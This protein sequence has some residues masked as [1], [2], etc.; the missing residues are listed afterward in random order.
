MHLRM[1]MPEI[2]V[3]GRRARDRPGDGADRPERERERKSFAGLRGLVRGR[4]ADPAW[5]RPALIGVAGL[6]GV[7][8]VWGLTVSGYANTYYAAAGQAASESW[9]A[10]FF[11][12]TD[13]S[14]YVSLDK[15]PLP[16][17][18]IGISG[19][20]FGFSS[21]SMLLP[22]A[23]C[24]VASV[25]ILHD[26]VRRTVGHR[27]AILAAGM[28]AVTPVTVLVSRYNNP[29]ALLAVLMVGA[30]WAIVRALESG[31]LRHL[32]ISAVLLGLA[33]NTKMLEA[34]L[35]LPALAITFL[36]AGPGG[37]GRRVG[38]TAVAGL[39]LG[40]VSFA[41]YGTMMLI[42]AAD[43]PYVGDST[44]NS[45][46][47]LIFGS[48][49]LSRVAG[50]GAG[51]P[52]FGGGGF[53]GGM[54]GTTGPLRLFDA[55]IGGQIAWLIPLALVGLVHGL[56]VRRA[57]PRTDRGRAAFLLLGLWAVTGWA[58]LSFSKGTFHAYYTSAIGPPVA[59]LAGAG[60]VGL[61]GGARRRLRVA[62]VL[63]ASLALT[64]W[65]AFGLLG[66]APGFAVWLPWAVLGAGGLS[67]VAVLAT[68]IR[69]WPIRRGLGGLALA[70]AGVAV[71]GGP[72]AYAIA[73]VGHGQTGSDPTA[74]PAG[75]G[76]GPG[77]AAGRRFAVA[78]GGGGGGF[79]AVFGRRGPAGGELADRGSA[80][81]LRPAGIGSPGGLRP[82]GGAGSPGGFGFAGGFAG[83][84]ADPQLVAYL[85]AHRDGAEYLVAAT[86]SQVAGLIQLA[87]GDPVVSM[88]GFMGADPAPTAAELAGLVRA[89]RV[90]YVLLG[91]GGFGGAAGPR[92]GAA[93]GRGDGG[94][95]ASV[96][97]ARQ[98][99][100]IG[101]CQTVDYGGS[102][103]AAGGRATTL[104]SCSAS[105]A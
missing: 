81:G 64:G 36:V 76:R 100:V 82:A 104:Y 86:G 49:G 40:V 105:D 38:R 90:R 44:N 62:G 87:S 21:L 57:A 54:G 19:R 31:R 77:D 60:L 94:A 56:W 30:A 51:G 15:G 66:D 33:F 103:G 46:F 45:W 10:M 52:G 23:A 67:A 58:V 72:S 4:P 102:T 41:W 89:G 78:G 80:G 99:W 70:C 1:S 8:M 26:L 39:V 22:D 6:A 9:H 25:V 47:G 29:D 34:Y 24:G 65:L 53:G 92:P 16:D 75:A 59:G 3:P 20:I 13:L 69:R 101:H 79:G 50:R 73:T 37:L 98:A 17:W 85:K 35:V 32:L 7:L 74:G 84:A 18:M 28:L 63:A 27:A 48:N 12:A 88:G 42:P 2:A 5:S 83:G 43:R 96:S 71:L 55:Q 97:T 68:G 11:N 14:G 95:S 91:G 61:A 93:G